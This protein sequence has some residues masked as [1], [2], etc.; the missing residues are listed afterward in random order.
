MAA[1]IPIHSGCICG[2][3]HAWWVH[4]PDHMKGWEAFGCTDKP[5]ELHVRQL[6]TGYDGK[7]KPGT[8][9]WGKGEVKLGVSGMHFG[10]WADN[11]DGAFLHVVGTER[12]DVE[13]RW[14]VAAQAF[15]EMR[16]T[17]WPTSR[18]GR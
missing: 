16:A 12:A 14:H 1:I 11:T 13:A 18:E 7:G 4:H 15:N 17:L 3:N 2:K 10:T 6:G 9:R 8:E 5:D